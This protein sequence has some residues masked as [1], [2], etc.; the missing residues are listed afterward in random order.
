MLYYQ[1]LED[2][3]EG[4]ELPS[5]YIDQLRFSRK[6][7]GRLT[8]TSTSRSTFMSTSMSIFTSTSTSRSTFM[9]TSMS[10]FTSTE[11]C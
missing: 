10:I 1:P 8:S 5:F 6:F 11:N 3:G 2:S 4:R 7:Y 9:S